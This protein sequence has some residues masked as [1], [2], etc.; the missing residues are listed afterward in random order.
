MNYTLLNR[1]EGS[2]ILL[3]IFISAILMTVGIGFN[4]IVK[5]HI[6]TA[7]VL[8]LKSEAMLNARSAFDTLIYL[9]LTGKKTRNGYV[10]RNGEEFLG[11]KEIPLD[12]KEV[13]VK[14]GVK[15]SLRDSN[16]MLSLTTLRKSAMERLIRFF[17]EENATQIIKS[18]LDW[19]DENKFVR[20]NG[21]ENFYY[22]SEGYSYTP[23][24]YPVQYKD[25]FMLVRGM[26]KEIFQNIEPHITILPTTGFNPN[27]AS[28]EVLKAYLNIE[29]EVVDSLVDYIVRKT[30][31][32]DSKLFS[33]TGRRINTGEDINFYP[34]PFLEITIKAGIPESYYTIYAGTDMRRHPA[35]PY[36]IIFW[37]ED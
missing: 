12:G 14:D 28:R 30:I 8:K 26:N 33:L 1:Q 2:A 5:E 24:N 16:G 27:T 19:T 10:L 34:S 6:K 37:R 25:E 21:A 35:F 17:S 7:E 18:Y 29:D 32:S 20:I 22:T 13:L 4:W 15:I 3:V 23:R 11:I 9:T 36:S 31:F